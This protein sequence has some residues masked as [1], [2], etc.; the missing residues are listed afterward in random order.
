MILYLDTSSLVK[1]YLDEPCSDDVEAWI[2]AAEAVA[3]SR[4]TYP[5]I[6]SALARRRANGALSSRDVRLSL[7]DLEDSW[8]RYLIVDLAERRAAR[9][10]VTHVL[11][12][13]DAIH[14][15]AAVTLRDAVGTDGLAF[16][17]FDRRLAQAAAGE[18]LIVLEP[19]D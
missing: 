8:E 12:G 18:G 9:L 16:S 17:S 7:D 13:I 11:R 3:T 4:V 15:A 14:L 19:G 5:E 1:A 2:D 10:A 6:A